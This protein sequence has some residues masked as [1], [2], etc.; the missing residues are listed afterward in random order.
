MLG[1]LTPQQIDVVLR[2]ELVG[3]IG[4]YGDERVAIVPSSYVYD[5]TALYGHAAAGL[6]ALLLRAHPQVCFQVDRVQNLANWQSVIVCGTFAELTGAEAEK[7]FDLFLDRMTPF[8]T[9]ETMLS[10]HVSSV[11][12]QATDRTGKQ[13]TMYR[14]LLTERSGRYEKSDR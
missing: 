14:I 9:S 4:C 1:I 10:A 11:G 3:R 12:G 7:A 2:S 5:G 8:I 6:K 13:A